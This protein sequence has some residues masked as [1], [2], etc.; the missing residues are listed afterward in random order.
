MSDLVAVVLIGLTALGG[1]LYV[2]RQ[3][4]IQHSLEYRQRHT[5]AI[6]KSTDQYLQDLEAATTQ[7]AVDELE[8]RRRRGTS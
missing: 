6:A 4:R 8:E 2:I 7:D 3:W 1:V 5:R